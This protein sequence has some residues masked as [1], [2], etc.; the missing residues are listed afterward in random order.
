MEA[1]VLTRDLAD[2]ARLTDPNFYVDPERFATYARLRREA[3]V[4]WCEEG[5]FWALSKYEDIAWCDT[6]KNPPLTTTQGLYILEATRPDRVEARDFQGT[7]QSGAGFTADPPHHTKFRGLVASAFAPARLGAMQSQI[8][9]YAD[10][11]LDA[12]PVGEPVDFVDTLSVPLTMGL[13]GR[14]LGVPRELW[15]DLR[16]WS[17]SFLLT[18]GGAFSEGS[19]EALQ[20]E[21]DQKAMFAWFTE[22]TEAR[23]K[24]PREDF[25]STIATVELDGARLSPPSQVAAATGLMTAGNDTTRNTLSGGV[26][27]FAEYPD[28]WT[29]V[30]NDPGLIPTATEEMVRWVTSVIH[31]GRRATEPFVLRGQ[32]IAKGDFIVTLFESG[33][34]DET[35]WENADVFDVTRELR[36]PHLGFGWGIHRCVGAALA[37]MQMRIVL[38][39]L[40]KRFSGWELDGPPE[41]IPSTLLNVYNHVPVVFSRR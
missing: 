9:Q 15:G 12:L 41:R 11:L 27:A 3:P 20:A 10:E 18:L 4:Y 34:R 17:D 26:V 16:R 25:M 23:L 6:Q 28:Q 37:R 30:V 5:Q 7:Q 32:E 40:A 36:P 35:V 21:E 22:A 31:F 2:E 19:A 38:N 39:G 14:F 13:I 24:E 29:K 8:Q 1:R 33:N